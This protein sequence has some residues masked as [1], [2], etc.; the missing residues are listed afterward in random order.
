MNMHKY[1]SKTWRMIRTSPEYKRYMTLK[2]VE[3]RRGGTITR[4]E[5][6]TRLDRAHAVGYKAKQ[7][8]IVVRV[9][10]RK[11][12]LRKIPPKLG[13]R[14]K[15][16]GISKIKRGKS[17]R[18]IAEERAKKKFR[19]LNIVGS[20]YLGEDGEYIWYEIVMRD[21]NHPSIKKN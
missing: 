14:Q 4:I 6:P 11:G 5:K 13:R 16:T 8:Y 21:E 20:Y 18:K 12:G 19:N 1:I 2:R 7:G 10:V 15:R 17:A 3:W 9:K